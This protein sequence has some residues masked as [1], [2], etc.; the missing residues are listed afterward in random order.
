MARKNKKEDLKDAKKQLDIPK[1]YLLLNQTMQDFMPFDDIRSM[2]I[3]LPNN[4]YRAVIE[5][6][7]INYYLKTDSE[8]ETLE[9]MFRN[10]LSSWDFSFAFYTQTRTIDAEE[11]INTLEDDISKAIT[12]E[13]Y[14]YGSQF[15]REMENLTRARNGNL[16]KKNYIIVSCNDADIINPNVEAS[17][18]ERY[19]FD[20][21]SIN[22]RKVRDS[23]APMGLDCKVLSNEELIELLFV[24][25]NKHSMLKADE[26][27]S[28][29]T[30]IT[31]GKNEWDV[32]QVDLLLDGLI[33][34][35][36]KLVNE[37]HDLKPIDYDRAQQIIR[38]IEAIKERN[39]ESGQD[40][41]VL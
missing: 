19:A 5:V 26:I 27:L 7:P 4:L 35:L 9:A 34:Q 38:E 29:T 14:A 16:I 25:L 40:L 37:S 11:I 30:N 20:R 12:K 39:K 24:A 1:D 32:N 28:H 41:F 10:A 13:L 2:M 36:H 6:E 31:Y 21:L 15:L 23:L 17:E 18:K 33:N 3:C 8:Q 22:V